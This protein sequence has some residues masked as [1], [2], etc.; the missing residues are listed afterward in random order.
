MHFVKSGHFIISYE[1]YYFAEKLLT[2]GLMKHHYI[3]SFEKIK[4]AV[5]EFSAQKGKELKLFPL[6]NLSDPNYATS[7][8]PG[9]GHSIVYV[10]LDKT[11]NSLHVGTTESPGIG[12]S[13][14]FGLNQDGSCRPKGNWQAEP[15]YLLVIG[16]GQTMGNEEEEVDCSTRYELRSFIKDSLKESNQQPW[17]ITLRELFLSV[18]AEKLISSLPWLEGT[19]QLTELMYLRNLLTFKQLSTKMSTDRFYLMA[20][21][22][23]FD[24]DF[25]PAVDYGIVVYDALDDSFKLPID[26]ITKDFSWLMNLRIYRTNEKI[27]DWQTFLYLMRMWFDKKL[28]PNED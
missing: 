20:N 8:W 28:D 23:D 11:G 22:T 19:R 6:F 25:L 15:K 16:V 27:E 2:I 24:L 17:F 4:K 12:L 13:N 7:P 9:E 14:Y 10:V 18:T 26:E 3:S 5:I 21:A 1:L